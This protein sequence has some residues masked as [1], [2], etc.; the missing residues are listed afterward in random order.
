MWY[1]KREINTSKWYCVI[2]RRQA[3]G[4][5]ERNFMCNNVEATCEAKFEGNECIMK[6]FI[7]Q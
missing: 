5:K 6:L 2:F 1:D 4:V 7:V 3:C